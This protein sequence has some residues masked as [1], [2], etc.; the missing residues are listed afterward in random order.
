MSEIFSGKKQ[1]IKTALFLIFCICFS[2]FLLIHKT[3]NASVTTYYIDFAS[4]SDSNAGT[5]KTAPWQR[6]PGM[7][8]FAG[9]YI[10]IAGDRFIFKGGVTW[11]ATIAPWTN[12]N[13]GTAGNVDYYGVDNTWYTGGSWTRPIFDGGGGTSGAVSVT[14]G[15]P[16]V[17]WIS[18]ATFP[19]GT[20]WNNFE[21]SI[22]A[23]APSTLY[24]ISSAASSI[25]LT[26]TSNFTGT[27]G[28]YSYAVT[29]AQN[30]YFVFNGSYLTMDSLQMQ[31]I[32]VAGTDQG[33]YGIVFQNSHNILVENM[34]MAEE[35]RICVYAYGDNGAVLQNFSFTGND[36]SECSWGI[37]VGT[38][39]VTSVMENVTI[40]NNHF[41]NFHDQIASEPSAIFFACSDMLMTGRETNRDMK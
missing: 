22:P 38:N 37:A 14:N 23:S 31:N 18:G 29:S 7:N 36:I 34:T 9:T 21:I 17:T 16:T 12:T 35:S 11:D 5:S 3:S 27:S 10:H 28:T 20:A 40:A 19:T 8:G 30:G 25:S 13:S 33:N 39:N 41:H 15:S 4:G 26:L 1:K 24:K 32:G 2:V 6:A